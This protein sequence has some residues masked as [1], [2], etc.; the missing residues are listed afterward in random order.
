MKN[1]FYITYLGNKRQEV[2]R[3]YEVIDFTDI[4]TIIE[5]FCGSCAMSYYISTKKEGLKY[6]L[7]DNNPYLKDMYEIML[8]DDKI[9][10]FENDYSNLFI[11]MDKEKYKELLKKEG[12]LYWF[13]ANKYYKIR[14]TMYPNDGSRSKTI[15]LKSVPIYNFFK[16]NDITFLTTDGLEL[17]KK[18][19]NCKNNLILL[20]PPYMDS[21][22]ALYKSPTINIYEY[23]YNNNINNCNSYIILIL[24]NNYI[25]RMLFSNNKILSTYNKTYNI[26]KKKT[27]HVIICNR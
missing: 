18:Y 25:I 27:E 10:K 3:L 6:I 2:E 5:P 14:P 21:C 23:L 11:D 17:Y 15:N 13:L 24:E 19:N 1:H 12:V 8:D 26:A 9:K 16:N 20:D 4:T 22:N 7:N